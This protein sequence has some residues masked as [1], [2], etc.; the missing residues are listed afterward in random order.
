MNDTQSDDNNSTPL[1]IIVGVL[2]LELV[3]KK[4]AAAEASL[5]S[6]PWPPYQL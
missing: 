2:Y 4:L 3:P 5:P 1:A 6:L